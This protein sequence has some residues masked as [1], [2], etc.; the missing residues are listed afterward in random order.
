MTATANLPRRSADEQ[1]RLE[2]MLRDMFEHRIC[3]NEVL[4]FHVESLDPGAA[5]IS[6]AM[7][8]DLVGHYLH[9]RLHGGVISTAL[10]TV[11][12][13]VVTVAIGEKY[14]NEEAAAVAHRAE[15]EGG[16][17]VEVGRTRP[18]GLGED[19]VPRIV[20]AMALRFGELAQQAHQRIQRTS[21]GN[22]RD[23]AEIPAVEIRTRLEVA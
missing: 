7:R 8:P 4:G 14:A 23:R 13:F 12:G 16:V 18:L 17:D 6:F 1:A 10:D 22:V 20:Q 21:A 3:F 2:S 15:V 11:G 5:V 19:V 9:G